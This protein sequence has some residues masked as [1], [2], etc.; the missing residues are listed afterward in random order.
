[1]ARA[2]VGSF[3][4]ANDILD[5]WIGRFDL[6]RAY[7]ELGAFTEADS[8]FDRCVKRRGEALALFLG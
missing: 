2:A 4:E 3:T 1:M 8:E 6:G 5:T 7:L